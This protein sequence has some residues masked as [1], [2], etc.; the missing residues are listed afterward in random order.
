MTV[1]KRRLSKMKGRKRRTH[2]VAAVPA[3]VKCP[4]C[5]TPVRPHMVCPKCGEY[6]KRRF[7]KPKE[8]G[9]GAG[10]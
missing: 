4:V 9:A 3:V 6:R 2:Y 8:A 5:R 7:I 1:P 10:S